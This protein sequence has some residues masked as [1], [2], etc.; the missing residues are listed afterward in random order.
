M[1]AELWTAFQL[2]RRRLR[3]MAPAMAGQRI[4]GRQA[5]RQHRL[6]KGDTTETEEAE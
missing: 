5:F 3:L 2:S 4:H 1:P 6:D